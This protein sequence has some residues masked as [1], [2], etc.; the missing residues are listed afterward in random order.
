MVFARIIAVVILVTTAIMKL[1]A[2]LGQSTDL[3]V[4][5]PVLYFL[6]R[7]QLFVASAIFELIVAAMLCSSRLSRVH[8]P[9]LVTLAWTFLSYR[10]VRWFLGFKGPCLCS[11]YALA[12][13]G[14]TPQLQD[15]LMKL[16]LTIL[17]ICGCILTSGKRC[18]N[19]LSATLHR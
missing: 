6:N 9:V 15:W 13:I 4:T 12:Q 1:V 5:D 14:L 11:G 3:F 8:G 18:A 19:R 2:S 10:L 7:G 17:L 16:L